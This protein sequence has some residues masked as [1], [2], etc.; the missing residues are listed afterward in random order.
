MLLNGAQLVFGSV[1]EVNPMARKI[2][3]F[4][5]FNIYAV[6]ILWSF[7]KT[8]AYVLDAEILSGGER[9]AEQLAAT[10]WSW[11][12]HY[13]WRLLAAIVATGLPAFLCGA[14]SRASAG[15]TAIAANV[16]GVLLWMV[17]LYLL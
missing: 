15:K 4:L 13:I 6:L 10:D 11:R 16:P 2:W 5:A 3:A 12:D 9:I 1:A 17:L 14:I 7:Q 8:A